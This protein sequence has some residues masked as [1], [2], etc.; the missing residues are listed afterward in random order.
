MFIKAERPSGERLHFPVGE[1]VEGA[2]GLGVGGS[3]GLGVGGRTGDTVGDAEGTPDASTVGAT[4]G[5]SEGSSI[6]S[7]G[8][9]EGSSEP[10]GSSEGSSEK[11][12]SSEGLS[13]GVSEP[14]AVGS[15]EGV[16]IGDDEGVAEGE[17]E[18]PGEDG[19][20]G[21][22]VT[23]TIE[24]KLPSSRNIPS[25]NSLSSCS[26]LNDLLS[27]LLRYGRSR[28][29]A[30]GVLKALKFWAEHPFGT[31]S[32]VATIIAAKTVR[33]DEPRSI[34]DCFWFVETVAILFDPTH[35][36]RKIL[37]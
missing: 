16:S 7:E 10:E 27:S 18:G 13:V 19:M 24:L 31:T 12:G 26:I 15:A 25:K 11:E 6:I 21:T 4:V 17:T 33:V 29:A 8:S 14:L 9:S 30:P 2:T 37:E 5:A 1:S 23:G 34:V 20:T 22:D 3:T 36:K 35:A 32:T 28:N